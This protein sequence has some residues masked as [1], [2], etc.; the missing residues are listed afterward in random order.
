[1]AAGS[2]SDVGL[3]SRASSSIPVISIFMP[4]A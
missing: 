1:M 4:M 2:A 3:I